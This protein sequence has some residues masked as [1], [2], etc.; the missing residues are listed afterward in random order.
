M[1]EEEDVMAAVYPWEA[2]R[3]EYIEGRR[4]DRGGVVYPTQEELAR[5]Y[6]CGLGTIAKRCG[7]EGWA[8]QRRLFQESQVVRAQPTI[9]AASLIDAAALACAERGI[10]KLSEFL[11]TIGRNPFVSF[12]HEDLL[13]LELCSQA[14]ERFSLVARLHAPDEAAA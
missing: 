12:S 13:E 14:L 1:L 3:T 6:T 8:Q 11:E 7:Q 4:D 5:K 10:A 2:I 9:S